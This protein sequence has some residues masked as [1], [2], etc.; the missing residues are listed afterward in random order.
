MAQ[1]MN[2]DLDSEE[3]VVGNKENAGY[4]HFLLFHQC[5]PEFSFTGW[6]K[7]QGMC[8]KG[9]KQSIKLEKSYQVYF[10]HSHGFYLSL[11]Q[12]CDKLYWYA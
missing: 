12:A 11:L 6:I 2:F 9:L 5:F 8:A 4:L 10:E 3:N 1:M 7:V